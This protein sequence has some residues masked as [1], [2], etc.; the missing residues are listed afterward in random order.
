MPWELGD[1]FMGQ[2]CIQ[3]TDPP[4]SAGVKGDTVE[5]DLSCPVD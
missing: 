3:M 1:G 2:A 5:P 4:P